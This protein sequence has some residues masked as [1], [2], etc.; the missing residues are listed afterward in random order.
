MLI[1]VTRPQP[2]ADEWVQALS[3]LDTPAQALPLID[4]GAPADAAPVQQAWR[5][6]ASTRL[7]MFVSPNAAL[8]FARLRPAGACWPANTLCAAPGPG[9]ARV[10]QEQLHG[11]GLLPQQIISP[12]PESAQFDSEHLWPLLAPLDWQGQQTIVISGG[13][14]Q[15]AKG[16]TWLSEQLQARGAQVQAVLSYQRQC[17]R[18]GAD[19]SQ[20][21]AQAR[22]WPAQHLW[23]LSSSEALGY[24][25]SLWGTVP[26]GALA[27]ATHPKV[28]ESA[29]AAGFGQVTTC[30]PSPEAVARARRSL[31]PA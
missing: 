15:E 2:Q 23:L 30:Q 22:Q 13:D 5:D 1:L 11:A 20:L 10:V 14:Q 26:G 6:L 16:R 9:T 18:W 27:L 12:P 25:Q 28:A 19:Q 8:W 4:I 7:V 3:E 31:M 21:A 29:L 24:L 17:A